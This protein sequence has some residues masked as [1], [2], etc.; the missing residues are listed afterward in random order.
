MNQAWSEREAMSILTFSSLGKPFREGNPK[1]Q[2]SP[3]T[4]GVS[5]AR[6]RD[7]LDTPTGR[8]STS[9]QSGLGHNCGPRQEVRDF[10][11]LIHYADAVIHYSTVT[12][13]Q[14]AV[15]TDG[16]TFSAECLDSARAALTA[17]QKCAKRFNVKGSEE[18]WS[19]YVNWYG[20][21]RD[22]RFLNLLLTSL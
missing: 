15:N 22:T 19:G 2:I 17:H 3:P 13:I 5:P 6:E 4:T 12:L 11:N 14:R 8:Q 10:Q 1:V 20:K 9:T 16:T 18:I 21:I 7:P